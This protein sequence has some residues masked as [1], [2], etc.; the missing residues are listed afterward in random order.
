MLVE[1]ARTADELF[2]LLRLSGRLTVRGRANRSTVVAMMTRVRDDFEPPFSVGHEEQ[3]AGHRCPGP[4]DAIEDSL[5][6]ASYLQFAGWPDAYR[7][8]SDPDVKKRVQR[9]IDE[10]RAARDVQAPVDIC[11]LNE[12]TETE[13][14]V[15]RLTFEVGPIPCPHCRKHL[16][17]GVL[18]CVWCGA[19]LPFIC[20]CEL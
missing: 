19:E 9:T 10:A 18:V 3:D 6:R 8:I 5:T 1:S 16:P 12:A 17:D 7:R 14:C 11:W 4:W 15:R 20:A 2:E 13:R